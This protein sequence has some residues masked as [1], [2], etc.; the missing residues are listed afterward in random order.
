MLLDL[1]LHLCP[2]SWNFGTGATARKI[3]D[4]RKNCD[5]YLVAQHH[6]RR[7]HF[8]NQISLHI[9]STSEHQSLTT[10]RTIGLIDLFLSTPLRSETLSIYNRLHNIDLS[11]ATSQI[12][13]HLKFSQP[14]NTNHSTDVTSSPQSHH[15]TRH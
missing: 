15:H 12:R 10:I 9:S 11:I 14:L 6:F 2:N 4:I 8:T 1:Y 3:I 7:R 5:Q 13:F